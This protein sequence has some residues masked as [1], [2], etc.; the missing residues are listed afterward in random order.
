MIQVNENLEKNK[1]AV[2]KSPIVAKAAIRLEDGSIQLI[3]IYDLSPRFEFHWIYKVKSARSPRKTWNKAGSRPF[4]YPRE[5]QYYYKTF[6]EFVAYYAN[7]KKAKVLSVKVFKK[8]RLAALYESTHEF[9][10]ADWTP[11]PAATD[12]K[13]TEKLNRMFRRSTRRI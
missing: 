8:R 6:R 10:S 2:I 3:V 11:R 1:Q 7:F 12:P 9:L 5:N 13:Q 4:F